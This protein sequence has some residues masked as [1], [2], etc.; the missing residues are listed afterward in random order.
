M[1][2]TLTNRKRLSSMALGVVFAFMAVLTPIQHVNAAS[3]TPITRSQVEARALSMIN[4]TWNYSSAK[5]GVIDPKYA[6]SVTKPAQLANVIN[7][8]FTG[9]PYNW[10]GLDSQ[11]S[12]STN[13]PWTSFADAVEK[14]AYTGNVNA[15][16]GMGYVPGTAGLDCSGFVQAAFDIK[17]W[18]L[19]TSTIF[20]TYFQKIALSDLKHMDILNKPGSHVVIFDAWGTWN[21]I[22]GAY[23]YEATPDQTRG[24]IQGTKRYFISMKD[25][26]NGYIPG[27]YVNIVEDPATTAPSTT[28]TYASTTPLLSTT[29]IPHP[30]DAGKF[31]QV[32]NV[33]YSANLRAS[34]S[35]TAAIVGTVPKGTILYMINY[36]N[37]WYQVNYNGTVGWIYGTRITPIPSGKYVTF[38][39]SSYLNIRANPSTT[40]AVLGTMVKNQYAEVLGYSADGQWYKISINGIKGWGYKTYLNYIY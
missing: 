2:R 24:G 23:T 40:A 10:G 29:T 34:A 22:E 28:V 36:S 4:F 30:V 39:G 31:A 20:N 9:I 8:Q 26:N 38:T 11:Y 14:G 16:A 27:R 33:T 7:G 12:I 13:A 1:M 32:A 37:G 21:G 3:Q 35:T 17:D 18:K 15:E 25:I 19:S 5:N 6:S